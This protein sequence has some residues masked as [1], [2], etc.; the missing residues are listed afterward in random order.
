MNIMI[1]GKAKAG[2]TSFV[3]SAMKETEALSSGILPRFD[4]VALLP[5]PKLIV[6]KKKEVKFDGRRMNLCIYDP[7]NRDYGNLAGQVD[8]VAYGVFAST[9]F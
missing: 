9:L 7:P 3:L 2:K 1:V 6:Q 5:P 8:K 4:Y